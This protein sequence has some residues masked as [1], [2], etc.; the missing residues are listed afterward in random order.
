MYEPIGPESGF[1]VRF[2]DTF[3]TAEVSADRKPVCSLGTEIMYQ[4]CF[5]VELPLEQEMQPRQI[6]FYYVWNG[7]RVHCNALRYGKF[8]PLTGAYANAYF[9]ANSWKLTKGRHCLHIAQI[10]RKEHLRC[11]CRFLKELW[12]KNNEAQER[13]LLPESSGELRKRFIKSLSG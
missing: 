2:G 6:H 4:L 11:E 12:K 5:R 7:N 10:G 3:F 1:Q 9:V 13:R 8:F